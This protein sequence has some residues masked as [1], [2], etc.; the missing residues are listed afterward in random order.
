MVEEWHTLPD[1]AK[2]EELQSNI[3]YIR[4]QKKRIDR[5]RH[6]QAMEA[7]R[8]AQKVQELRLVGNKNGD[9]EP[10]P[11]DLNIAYN[12]DGKVMQLEKYDVE[13]LNQNKVKTVKIRQGQQPDEVEISSI[14]KI[15]KHSIAER[16][17]MKD[18]SNYEKAPS[19]ASFV[20]GSDM[21]TNDQA[22]VNMG[23]AEL[24]AEEQPIRDMADFRKRQKAFENGTS[25][26][27][28][29]HEQTIADVEPTYGVRVRQMDD[30]RKR[31]DE[32]L[33]SQISVTKPGAAI[34]QMQ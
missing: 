8:A 18:M 3:E 14:Y 11:A 27:I 22:S 1:T 24:T 32:S 12:D 5:F 7:R 31:F 20:L 6:T 13:E 33:Q 16:K 28:K 23:D 2:E 34:Q 25:G 17:R 30:H 10:D 15:Y 4:R 19:I 21:A 29:D 9:I 26:A